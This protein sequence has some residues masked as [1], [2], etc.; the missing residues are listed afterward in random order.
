VIGIVIGALLLPALLLATWIGTWFIRRS[1]RWLYYFPAG[2]A[3]VLLVAAV[4]FGAP[5]TPCE[6]SAPMTCVDNVSL[7]GTANLLTG[8]WTWIALLALTALIE[9]ARQLAA[10]SRLRRTAEPIEHQSR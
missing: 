2:L 1:R 3:A 5:K 9:V 4:T 7:F 10:I 8:F 6:S